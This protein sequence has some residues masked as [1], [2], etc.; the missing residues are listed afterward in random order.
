M[1]VQ[2]HF[3]RTQNRSYSLLDEVGVVS[4]KGTFPNDELA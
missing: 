1:H 3:L 2:G 4:R